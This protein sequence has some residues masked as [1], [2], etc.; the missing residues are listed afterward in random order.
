M[1]GNEPVQ[2]RIKGRHIIQEGRVR[3][4]DVIW[5]TQANA[6][7]YID[8]GVAEPVLQQKK[9]GPSETKPA[10]AAESKPVGGSIEKNHS[11]ADTDTRS[12]D[13]QRSLER[14]PEASSSVS[15][16]DQVSRASNATSSTR[17]GRRGNRSE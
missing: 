7:A 15:A 16:P 4:G 10:A 12:I 5:T 2:V 13:S 11:G 3:D 1:A 17:G 6:K 14:G 8:Q 9:P